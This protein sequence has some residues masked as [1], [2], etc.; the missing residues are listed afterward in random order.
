[1]LSLPAGFHKSGELFNLHRAIA[2]TRDCVIVVEGFFDSMKVY[3]AGFPCVVALMGSSLSDVQ[4]E[5]LRRFKYLM[6][7]LDGDD[8]GREAASAIAG[9]LVHSQF[10][11][12]I[13][14]PDGKQP[15]MLSSD[16]IR[17]LLEQ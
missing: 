17:K 13:S 10:V 7:F 6:L 3:Q 5:H 14:L 12:V 9:R 15:D 2:S 16:E 8:A 1:M 4:Q 11:K